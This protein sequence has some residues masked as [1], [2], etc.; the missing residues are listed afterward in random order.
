MVPEVLAGLAV[1]GLQ[2]L[3]PGV[4]L[5]GTAVEPVGAQLLRDVR[6]DVSVVGASPKAVLDLRGRTR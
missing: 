3:H 1:A 2:P 5:A 4:A 6:E